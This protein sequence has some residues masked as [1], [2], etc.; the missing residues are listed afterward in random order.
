M[1][2]PVTNACCL[3][4]AW[5]VLRN[6]RWLTHRSIWYIRGPSVKSALLGNVR[7]MAYQENVGDLDFK[8]MREYGAVWKM[9][10]ALGSKV[11]MVAD[12]KALQ[13]IFHKSGYLYP[14]TTQARLSAFIIAGKNI[15][16]APTGDIHSRHRKVMNPAFST[17]QL[18]SFLPIFRK[19]SAKLCQLWK[20]QILSQA[21]GG[22]TILVNIWL[23]RTTLDVIGEAAFGFEFGALYNSDNELSKAYHNMFADSMLY[24]TAWN[25]VF[26]TLWD[27]IPDSILECVRYVP[28]REYAR[29]QYTMRIFNKY[30]QQLIAQ[31]SAA[32]VDD[33]SS[34]DVMSILVRAN[35]SEDPRSKLSD[36]EMVSEMCAL[37]LAGHET[38]AN[39]ITWM[40][41]E[42]AKH[43]EYQ[44]KL[45]VEIAQKRAEVI[46]RGESDFGVDDLESMGY[47]QA[48]IKETLRYHCIVF[49]LNR[50]ASQDDVIPLTY[51][52]VTSIGKTISEIPVA[53][54][55]V[56]MP[57]IAVYNRLPEMW[58][59][60]A[61]EWDPMRYIDGRVHTQIRLG[62]F[63]NLMTFSAGVRGCIGWRFSV[64]ETQAIVADLIENFQFSIPEDKP[65]IVRVPATIMSPMVKGMMHEGSQMPLHVTI[66]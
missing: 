23:A 30:S 60:D 55:Q 65:E 38:T 25:A 3:F 53:A 61:H 19:S 24:P 20:D 62:M 12:P 22:A 9:Q 63:E 15:L 29:F 17:P 47:F 51:P 10:Y 14:K 2:T 35:A 16:W 42:L 27:Y 45:R 28:T 37:T 46:A 54:G 34:R 21:P 49:H 50:V 31:K 41:W 13:H 39:T 6:Y 36:E 32:P 44:E 43:P 40:L 58:G 66:V 18:R 57:N 4:V 11:L 7:D 56:I 8:Y 48:T 5:L 59:A 1:F 33:K 26:Q 52:I 64:I